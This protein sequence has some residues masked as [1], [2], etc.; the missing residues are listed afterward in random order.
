MGDGVNMTLAQIITQEGG[1]SNDQTRE[2]IANMINEH[3]Y[4]VDVFD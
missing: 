2:Y 1:L 3:L 4:Q